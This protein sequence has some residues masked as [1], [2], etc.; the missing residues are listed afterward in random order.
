MQK[1]QVYAAQSTKSPKEFAAALGQVVTKNGFI[2]HNEG[3]MDMANSFA[4]HGA[5]VADGFDL[6]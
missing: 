3:T 2:I 1:E 5:E 6:T 4:K